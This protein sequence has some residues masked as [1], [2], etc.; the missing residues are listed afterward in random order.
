MMSRY[1]LLAKL[2]AIVTLGVMLTSCK[3]EIVCAAT[4]FDAADF[5][6]CVLTAESNNLTEEEVF[7]LIVLEEAIANYSANGDASFSMNTNGSS[8]MSIGPL[9]PFSSGVLPRVK[10]RTMTTSRTQHGQASGFF[11]LADFNRD[12]TPD[13]VALTPSGLRISLFRADGSTI[14]VK[15][16]PIANLGTASIVAADFNKDGNLDIAITQAGQT[17]G[18]VSVLLGN[19]DGTFGPPMPLPAIAQFPFYLVAAD[20]N[21]DGI[22]D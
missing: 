1:L 17:S 8:A 13:T 4:S 6:D 19:G 2:V 22:P 5:I 12:G 3:K 21:G 16:Y 14:S 9:S 20:L 15:P 7:A 11:V 18:S 10:P